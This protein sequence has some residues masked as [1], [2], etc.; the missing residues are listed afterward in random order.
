ML[1]AV[2]K[3]KKSDRAQFLPIKKTDQ[4]FTLIEIL[5][6]LFIVGILSAIALTSYLSI[7]K[8]AKSCRNYLCIGLDPIAKGCATDIKTI[9]STVFQ[10][11]TIEVRYSAKC[12]ASWA[13]I[14]GAFISGSS[15]YVE[16][17]EGNR[18]G[19]AKVRDGLIQHY[20]NMG[21]GKELRACIELPSGETGCTDF[22]N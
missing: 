12:D 22:P 17:R 10:G 7:V 3:I 13:R 6:A 9:A 5:V 2:L 14:T 1:P 19:Q 21:L 15:D 4:G 8:K 20:S 16:D 11:T 18:Y